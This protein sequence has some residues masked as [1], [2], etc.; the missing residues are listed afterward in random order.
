MCFFSRKEELVLYHSTKKKKKKKHFLFK[1]NNLI[2]S[3]I[4][5]HRLSCKIIQELTLHVFSLNCNAQSKCCITLFF[6]MPFCLISL[7]FKQRT[8]A[9]E[10]FSLLGYLSSSD[11]GLLLLEQFH[12]FTILTRIGQ[13][14]LRRMLWRDNNFVMTK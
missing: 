11:Q 10:Y 5:C 7:P 14:H 8:M 1:N 9:R 4:F 6:L 2:S 12:A 13:N 3:K